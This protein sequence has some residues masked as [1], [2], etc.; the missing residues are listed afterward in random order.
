VLSALVLEAGESSLLGAPAATASCGSAR[1]LGC[2]HLEELDELGRG[3]ERIRDR[4]SS[5]ER[6][7]GPE[8]AAGLRHQQGLGWDN[9]RIP[10]GEAEQRLCVVR[11]RSAEQ[12]RSV[13]EVAA[14]VP[15]HTTMNSYAGH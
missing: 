13:E 6:N 12:D 15:L 11:A 3:V 2:A 7:R 4:R 5:G 1:Q 8:L 14:A 9:C 10:L